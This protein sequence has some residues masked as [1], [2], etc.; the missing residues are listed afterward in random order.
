M[1]RSHI[2]AKQFPHVSDY[3]HIMC[4][5]VTTGQDLGKRSGPAGQNP[6]RQKSEVDSKASRSM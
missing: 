2:I 1:P 5:S 3:K 4:P 6:V